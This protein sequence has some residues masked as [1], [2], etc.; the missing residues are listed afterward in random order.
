MMSYRDDWD[1]MK[2]MYPLMFRIF[3]SVYIYRGVY[4]IVYPLV[5]VDIA[6]ENHHAIF[7]ENSLFR[8]PSSIYSYVKLTEGR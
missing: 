5:D 8:W 4:P 7:L 2:K 6:M 3:N 1:I